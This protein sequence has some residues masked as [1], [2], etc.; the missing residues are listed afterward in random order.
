MQQCLKKIFKYLPLKKKKC[1]YKKKDNTTIKL[2]PLLRELVSKA[3][4]AYLENGTNS[5]NKE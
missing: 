1:E 4:E 5:S 2:Q 3:I